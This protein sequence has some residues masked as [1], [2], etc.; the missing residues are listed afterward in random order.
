[1]YKLPLKWNIS[2][3]EGLDKEEIMFGFAT[4]LSFS[5]CENTPIPQ[6]ATQLRFDR[7]LHELSRMG[8]ERID[9]WELS[10]GF[11]LAY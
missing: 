2:F 5:V 9:V 3:L 7:V 1:M 6:R 11:H 10:A 8:K 4:F